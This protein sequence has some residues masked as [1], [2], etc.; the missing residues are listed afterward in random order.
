M[1]NVII[2]DSAKAKALRAAVSTDEA[3]P[4]LH[5]VNVRPDRLE[6]TTGHVCV[7]IKHDEVPFNGPASAD[8]DHLML[9]GALLKQ[10][11]NKTQLVIDPVAREAWLSPAGIGNPY[12]QDALSVFPNPFPEEGVPYPNIDQVYA[13]AK[14][15]KDTI[16]LRLGVTILK[17]LA[18]IAGA[19]DAKG[20]SLTLTIPIPPNG[21]NGVESAV[22]VQRGSV[23]NVEVEGMAMPMRVVN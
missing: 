17:A 16:T 11:K 5:Y 22:L 6:A 4:I 9:D 14:K 15:P 23:D 7:I 1:E 2:I 3:R 21:S 8:S 13:D 18:A 19:E 10:V 12:K 20:G